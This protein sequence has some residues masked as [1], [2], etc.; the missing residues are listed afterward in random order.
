MVLGFCFL[1][2]DWLGGWLTGCSG[3]LGG[4]PGGVRGGKRRDFDG[5]R[6]GRGRKVEKEI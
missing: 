6:L 3:F 5:G 4:G 2:S 1:L